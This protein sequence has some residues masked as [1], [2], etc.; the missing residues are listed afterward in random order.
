[1]ITLQAFRKISETVSSNSQFIIYRTANKEKLA[2]AY[3]YEQAKS[4]ASSI[5]KQ[6]GLKF[7]DVSFIT[8]RRFHGKST[9]AP[10]GGRRIEYAPRYNPSKRGRFKGIHHSDGSYGDID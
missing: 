10:S 4:K 1:M 7:D 3:G 2:T 8:S 6:R 9:T 5:R